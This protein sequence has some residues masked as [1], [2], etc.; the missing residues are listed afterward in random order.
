MG[1]Y[2][3]RDSNFISRTNV[4]LAYV[5]KG[6]DKCL[7]D[8]ELTKKRGSLCGLINFSPVYGSAYGSK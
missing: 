3:G 7:V 2:K 6:I 5:D 8:L 4:D 1:I